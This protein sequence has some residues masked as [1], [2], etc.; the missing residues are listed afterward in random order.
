MGNQR[1]SERAFP[2]EEPEFQVAPMI[3][4]LL[5]LMTFFMS[6]TSTEVLK[7]KSKLELDLPVAK[8]SKEKDSAQREIVVNV[9]WDTKKKQGS[10]EFEQKDITIPEFMQYVQERCGDQKNFRAVI[11]AGKEVPYSFVQEVMF[12]SA[13]G[14]VDNI[15]FMV[16]A[17]DIPKKY[18]DPK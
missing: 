3:D 8:E 6:I 9:A 5:V 13:Q 2:E 16:L 14:G 4:I 17:K 1:A 12:A 11:R 10:I 18:T 15:T 7:T